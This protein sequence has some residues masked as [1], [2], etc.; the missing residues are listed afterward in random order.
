MGML[1]DAR[2]LLGFGV[3]V[4]EER[5]KP[6]RVAVFVDTEA[7]EALVSTL[8]SVLHPQMSTARLHVE[9]VMPGDV[10]VVDD[11]ADAVIAIAGPGGTLTPSL[12]RSR[13]GFVPTALLVLGEERDAAARRLGH[14]L[15]DTIAGDDVD[16][17]VKE[18]AE[19]LADRLGT[20]R[21][22]LAANFAFVR[23]AVAAESVKA[24]ALQ[25]GI[26]GGVAIIPGADMP[27]M[28]ANQAKMLLQIAAA[29]GQPLGAE[30]AKELVAVVGGAFV[31]RTVARQAATLIP[32]FGWALKA[33][34]GYS[35]TIAMGYAAI[36]YF[37]HGG[38]VSGLGARVRDARD[39]AI[40]LARRRRRGEPIPAH[41]W[42]ADAPGS[43][44]SSAASPVA[45]PEP[46]SEA[47]E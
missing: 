26:I 19:W 27:L 36:D 10:L 33:G 14:P 42:V 43:S 17:L 41:A 1:L 44:T 47:G 46:V 12:A 38:D 2:D 7:P 25:N 16:G 45:L 34:I 11:A 22:A 30:R 9:P 29:Y 15:L 3:R 5:E 32:G 6:V 28:T 24:T 8:K 40:E 23:T 4:R 21:L 13:D 20:K 31:M 35:G 18:L 39:R 37:E